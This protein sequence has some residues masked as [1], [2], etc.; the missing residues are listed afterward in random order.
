MTD[1]QVENF[2]KVLTMQFGAAALMLSKE[3]I[4]QVRDN[5]QKGLEADMAMLD[6]KKK[7]TFRKERKTKRKDYVSKGK[8][9]GPKKSWFDKA[10]ERD[11]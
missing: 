2:R 1:E 8:D 4:I 7:N 9:T 5:F 6:A 3:Q 11:H 10:L